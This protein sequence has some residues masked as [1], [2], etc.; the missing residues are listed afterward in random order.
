[1]NSRAFLAATLAF[2]LAACDAREPAADPDRAEAP[3]PPAAPDP[4]QSNLA[5]AAPDPGPAEAAS[6]PA[7]PEPSP[8]AA[9]PW[10]KSGYRLV[11]TEP[12]WGGTVE[13]SKILYMTPE[14]QSGEPVA[15]SAS[16]APERETWRGALAGKPFVLTLSRAPCSDGMSDKVHAFTATLEVRGETRSGCADP[17]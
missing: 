9:R 4:P 12:F 8:A 5:A 16:Y 17:R 14:N 13:G 11:G 6:P 10:S 2:V 3:E 7:A 1:M 15:A